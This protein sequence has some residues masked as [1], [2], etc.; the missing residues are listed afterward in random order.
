V[1]F[2][3]AVS[4]GGTGSTTESGARINL[5]G[6][7]V[8][9]AVFTAA[10]QV[11]ARTAIDAGQGTVT[12]VGGTGTVSGISLSG[13]VT[14][15]GNLTLTGPLDLSSPPAIGGT[16]PA[17]GTFST[18]LSTTMRETKTNVS[19]VLGVATLNLNNG[20]YFTYTVPGTISFAVTNVPATNTAVSLIL[21]LTNG[22][23]GTM[24]WW[25]NVK[26]SGGT[27]PTLTVS[28][29]DILGFYTYDNGTTWNGLVL[30][31]DMK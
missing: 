31:K 22:G 18:L 26:W 10:S 29:R 17:A 4:Q 27:A 15:S 25:P 3:V 16:T 6:T 20:N 30:G 21:D 5:G 23:S 19:L 28:G 2:P 24:I 13:T 12:S 11:D 8:G 9:I 7:S 1:A 14:N